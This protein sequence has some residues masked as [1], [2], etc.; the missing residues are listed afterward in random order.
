M[1]ISGLYPNWIE[2]VGNLGT[3]Y[4][5]LASEMGSR[6]IGLNPQLVGSDVISK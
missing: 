3:Y 6:L 1:G 5:W 2:V 4:L